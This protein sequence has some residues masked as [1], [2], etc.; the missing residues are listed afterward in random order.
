MPHVVSAFCVCVIFRDT[1]ADLRDLLKGRQALDRRR[2]EEAFLLYASLEVLHKHGLVLKDIPCN[3][4][5]LAEAVAEQFHD[6][7]VKKWGGKFKVLFYI[8][9]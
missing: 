1:P 3:R 8:D 2:L 6:A 9:K 5:N 7:F 4:N